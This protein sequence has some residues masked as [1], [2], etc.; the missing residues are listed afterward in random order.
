MRHHLFNA[1]IYIYILR[2]FII[3]FSEKDQ[4]DDLRNFFAPKIQMNNHANDEIDEEGRKRELFS[5]KFFFRVFIF[6]YFFNFFFLL[7]RLYHGIV[8]D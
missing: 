1:N 3:K 4:G 7:P 6:F 5:E 2:H 8:L